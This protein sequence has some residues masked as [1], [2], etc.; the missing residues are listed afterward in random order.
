MTDR[1]DRNREGGRESAGAERENG[2]PKI[3]KKTK[4][5]S[6]VKVERGKS[7]KLKLKSET[8]S[9]KKHSSARRKGIQ[10]HTHTQ[11]LKTYLGKG[12]KYK[13]K[14]RQVRAAACV[15]TLAR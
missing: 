2:A 7:R 9:P 10:T 1:S 14:T 12:R 13:G 6:H 15:Q 11:R 8:D 4:S 5:E 3:D